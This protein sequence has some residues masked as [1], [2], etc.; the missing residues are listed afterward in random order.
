MQTNQLPY[1]G[2]ESVTPFRAILFGKHRWINQLE[3]VAATR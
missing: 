3:G 2:L 1:L